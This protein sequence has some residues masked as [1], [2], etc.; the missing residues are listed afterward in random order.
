MKTQKELQSGVVDYC[1]VSPNQNTTKVAKYIKFNNKITFVDTPALQLD[2]DYTK[3][4]TK[5]KKDELTLTEIP[6]VEKY[7]K[8]LSS[9]KFFELLYLSA[10][11]NNVY[12]QNII[13]AA[14]NIVAQLVEA[15]DGKTPVLP[16]KFMQKI[17]QHSRI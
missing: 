16:Q 5:G 13:Y 11:I 6:Y 17:I 15:K 10:Y 3:F 7:Q 4:S 1:D 9:Y 12:K 14:N 2:I 8:S